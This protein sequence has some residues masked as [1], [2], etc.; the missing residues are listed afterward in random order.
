MIDEDAH[1]SIYAMKKQDAKKYE[2]IDTELLE[3]LNESRAI[4]K[5]QY[6]T[7]HPAKRVNNISKIRNTVL[8]AIA[9]KVITREELNAILAELEANPRWYTRNSHLF[10]VNEEGKLHLSKVGSR[11]ASRTKLLKA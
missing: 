7:N 6:T 11:I 5:R 9:D 3:S 4:Y 2:T 8:E 10:K 1:L